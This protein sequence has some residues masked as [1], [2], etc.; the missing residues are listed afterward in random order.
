MTKKICSVVFAIGSFVIVIVIVIIGNLW[1]SYLSDFRFNGSVRNSVE[2][3]QL[4][5]PISNFLER[6]ITFHELCLVWDLFFYNTF[7]INKVYDRKLELTFDEKKSIE[8]SINVKHNV[9]INPHLDPGLLYNRTKYLLEAQWSTLDTSFHVRNSFV[10]LRRQI[11]ILHRYYRCLNLF[12][13]YVRCMHLTCAIFY[14]YLINATAY[15]KT[16]E[17]SRLLDS[18][19][20]IYRTYKVLEPRKSL[21]LIHVPKTMGT[22]AC[23]TG[24]HII[25]T[26][27]LFSLH[28]TKILQQDNLDSKPFLTP[29]AICSHQVDLCGN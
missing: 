17:F 7:I 9:I 24:M 10:K 13:V 28:I 14:R 26:Q 23:F 11:M 29:I 15:T 16:D 2:T 27:N 12:Y 8:S 3:K 21:F 1:E 5:H 19:A 22:S 25:Q 4:L 18:V 6:N 20:H